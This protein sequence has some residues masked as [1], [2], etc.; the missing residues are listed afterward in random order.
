MSCQTTHA[1]EKGSS[2]R[3]PAASVA[4]LSPQDRGDL[5][6]TVS[7]P[8][9]VRR[10]DGNPRSTTHRLIPCDPPRTFPRSSRFCSW[11]KVAPP[12]PLGQPHGDDRH[13]IGTTVA[14]TA[15]TLRTEGSG[16]APVLVGDSS[17]CDVRGTI[18]FDDLR[19]CYSRCGRHGSF[20]RTTQPG[21]EFDGSW[22][23][24]VDDRLRNSDA[25]QRRRRI[26]HSPTARGEKPD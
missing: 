5:F 19:T 26:S 21:S 14:T 1:S 16:I 8:A 9:K 11:S 6:S 7:D 3:A 2:T 24:M 25:D 13:H 22:R 23:P 17:T 20:R 18:V 12:T 10:P 15:T 4:K